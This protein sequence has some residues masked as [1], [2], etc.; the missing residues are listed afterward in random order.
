MELIYTVIIVFCLI[1][2]FYTGYKIGKE[3]ALPKVPKQIAHPIQ[4]IKENEASK[5]EDAKIEAF[6][7]DLEELD[8]YGG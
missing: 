1:F 8:N 7:K 2:G 4:T 3:Q 6:Q 5:E